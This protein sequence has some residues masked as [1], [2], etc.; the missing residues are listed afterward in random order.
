MQ[1]SFIQKYLLNKKGWIYAIS[2]GFVLGASLLG[3]FI[4]SVS[5]PVLDIIR[6]VFHHLF[7]IGYVED[8]PRNMQL[9]IWEIRL[10][11]I[12]LAFLVGAALSIAGAVFQALLRNP[13]ADP[14]TIGISSGA[15][16]GAV[17]VIFFQLQWVLFG[18]LTLP[19]VAIGFGMLTLIIVLAMASLSGRNLQTETII[20]AGIMMSSFIGAVISL[21]IAL[22]DANGLSQI[23][24]WLMGS[25]RMRGWEH[26][27]IFL[28]FFVVG[29][30]LLL[31]FTRD[32]NAMAL[33]DDGAH[34]VGM[35]VKRKKIL[36]LSGAAILTGAS[37]SVSGAIGFVGLV[38]P[39]FVRLLI[40]SNYKHIIPLSMWIGGGYL[41]LC[42]LLSRTVI[43]PQELP[44]GVITAIVGAPIFSIFL[45][46]KR[47]AE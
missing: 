7:S 13:L 39:H 32:M 6:V 18:G 40:G 1:K 42:D 14:Y 30:L 10:P 46:K 19:I 3:L 22:S 20:L 38:I 47:R 5:Y 34:H 2:G 23:V 37:V 4:S 41:V 24:Y 29:C 45:I 21:L 25:F 31:P 26:V 15:S 33:G 9:I 28:P 17:I 16:L 44:I 43:V 12:V 27:Q 35:N 36:L 11:R 8:V